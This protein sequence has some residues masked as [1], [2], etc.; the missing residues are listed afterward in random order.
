MNKPLNK[1]NLFFAFSILLGVL[2]LLY[3]TYNNDA[4]T[5]FE[6]GIILTVCPLI[7]VFRSIVFSSSTENNLFEFYLDFFSGNLKDY[8]IGTSTLTLTFITTQSIG[9]VFLISYFII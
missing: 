1:T 2:F 5:L 7:A 4:F 6:S 9:L 8:D 3:K